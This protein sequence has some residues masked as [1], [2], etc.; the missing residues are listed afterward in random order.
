MFS[1]LLE[2]RDF[3]SV[4][5]EKNRTYSS[6]RESRGRIRVEARDPARLAAPGPAPAPAGPPQRA[7]PAPP[8]RAPRTATAGEVGAGR[9]RRAA[10][11]PCARSPRAGAR[12]RAQ[13]GQQGVKPA[14]SPPRAR[15]G[16]AAARPPA[17]LPPGVPA[18]A[19]SQPLPCGPNVRSVRSGMRRP[20]AGSV[21]FDLL[22]TAPRGP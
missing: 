20:L 3:P 1:S 18:E 15:P 5:G 12:A 16:P 9:G 19:A 21:S 4:L 17:P 11:Q 2:A 22:L 13:R 6:V 14:R 7:R 10:R 8:D